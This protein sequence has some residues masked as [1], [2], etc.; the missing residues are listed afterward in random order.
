M[1]YSYEVVEYW[2]FLPKLKQPLQRKPE[3][4]FQV[5]LS[6]NNKDLVPLKFTFFEEIAHKLNKFLRRFQRD[7]PMVHFLT[8][9]N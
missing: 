2:Q 1:A 6:C 4:N 3:N 8:E 7:A 9:E 5:L